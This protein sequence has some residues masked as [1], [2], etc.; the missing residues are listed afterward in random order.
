MVASFG[1]NITEDINAKLMV[2]VLGRISDLNKWGG[3]HE[4]ASNL[5]T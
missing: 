5:S 3:F 4:S 1:V 2:T